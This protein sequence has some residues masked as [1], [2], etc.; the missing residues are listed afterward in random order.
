MQKSE[1]LNNSIP[2]IDVSKISNE[3][4]KKTDVSTCREDS[5]KEA[6]LSRI[7]KDLE[8]SGI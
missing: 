2:V 3:D 4:S 5:A 6:D 7:G 1:D 8:D